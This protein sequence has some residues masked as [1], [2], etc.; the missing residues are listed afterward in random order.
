MH[1]L[2]DESR[3]ATDTATAGGRAGRGHARAGRLAALYATFVVAVTMVAAGIGLALPHLSKEGMTPEA[4][5]GLGLL[6]VGVMAI[7]WAVPRAMSGVRLHWW[8]LVLPLL[9]VTSY[10]ALWTVGQAVAASFPA[11]P[12]LGGRTPASL[13]LPYRDVTL[14]T[15]DGV[16]LAA[17]WVPSRNDAAVALL[18]GSGST[19][20]A[21]L[22]H[23]EVLAGAG[24]GVLLVDARGH[25]ESDGPGMDFG[26]YGERDAAA[27]VDFLVSRRGVSDDRIGLVGL[28]MGGESAIGAAGA[29]PRVRAVVA[30]GATN[31]VAADKA[32]L[33]EYGVRGDLQQG[34]DAL[35]YE[36]TDLLTDAP[37]P[38]S[39]HDSVLAA[40][41]DG[42]PTPMLLVA[43]GDVETEQLAASH[44]ESAAPD[45]VRT[46][47]VPG[48]GHTGGLAAAPGAWQRRVLGFLD[49]ALAGG[50]RVDLTSPGAPSSTR[51]PLTAVPPTT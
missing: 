39:L 35:T 24:Y 51:N 47:T 4:W 29:D 18:H 14:R 34:I 49:T 21:V 6:V 11:H 36:V 17:W 23:A 48:A 30:E 19:R 9:L 16:G 13:G 2:V 5:L 12:E 28:S 22:E 45:A 38:T 26:W 8:P 44:L 37:E 33:E 46:W 32:F 43:A 40:Q 20:T 42:T 1:T 10:V 15:S 3:G 50:L 41:R 7:G 25:G 31:R 27:A